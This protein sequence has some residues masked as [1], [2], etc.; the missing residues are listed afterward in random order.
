MVASNQSNTL[1]PLGAVV[2]IKEAEEGGEEDRKLLKLLLSLLQNWSAGLAGTLPVT[3]GIGVAGGIG[4][5]V[6]G[7]PGP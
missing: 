4:A 2:S 3:V 7:G 6:W 1:S 5:G